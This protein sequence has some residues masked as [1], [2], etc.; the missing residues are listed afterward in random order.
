MPP[1]RRR[2]GIQPWQD[3]QLKEAED[4]LNSLTGA[5]DMTTAEIQRTLRAPRLDALPPRAITRR[6]NVP[7]LGGID[8][9]RLAAGEP[10]NI[11][12]EWRQGALT[13][14][15]FVDAASEARAKKAGAVLDARLVSCNGVALQGK[16]QGQV[17]QRMQSTASM[18]RQLCFAPPLT[19][20]PPP[21]PQSPPAK[22]KRFAAEDDPAAA[23]KRRLARAAAAANLLKAKDE[24]QKPFAAMEASQVDLQPQP[25]S[26]DAWLGRAPAPAVTT[27][28]AAHADPYSTGARRRR[29][30]HEHASRVA[31]PLI[32]EALKRVQ[33]RRLETL[34]AVAAQRR[35]RGLKGRRKAAQRRYWR[36]YAAA[37]AV[38]SCIRGHQYRLRRLVAAVLLAQC[39]IRRLRA[40]R[41][42]RRMRAQRFRTRAEACLTAQRVLRGRRGRRVAARLRRARV[43]ARRFFAIARVRGVPFVPSHRVVARRLLTAT[44]AQAP[45][46]PRARLPAVAPGHEAGEAPG[47]R[48]AA[49]VAPFGAP[50]AV[51][52]DAPAVPDA[53][54]RRARAG[55]ADAAR[56]RV[57]RVARRVPEAAPR[58]RHPR[59]SGGA[60]GGG[61]AAAARRQTRLLVV[62]VVGR[63]HFRRR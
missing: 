42:L 19:A 20:P 53:L 49:L 46:R 41:L 48:G 36:L 32:A 35:R 62:V 52:R 51:A 34:A 26:L 12:F 17:M 57:G 59:F 14:V 10:A 43:G 55:D 44:P 11:R 39:F 28:V 30:T 3:A 27:K 23:R 7:E 54:P 37:V 18:A 38:Q 4:L 13:V 29:I 1:R 60:R 47:R 9:L 16:S 33:R 22:A 25:P 56:R 21:G 6:R 58:R 8:A 24:P 50:V 40:R 63:L 2:G 45:G 5:A 15:G 31:R 61:A